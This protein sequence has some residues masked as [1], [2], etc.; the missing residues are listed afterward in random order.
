MNIIRAV[1]H[2]TKAINDFDNAHVLS[3]KYGYT[4]EYIVTK[5]WECQQKYGMGGLN[6]TATN[7]DQS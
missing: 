3:D 7:L 4:T 6:R 2:K 5:S 1:P